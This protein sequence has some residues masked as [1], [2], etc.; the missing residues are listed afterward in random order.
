MPRSRSLGGHQL[1]ALP[2]AEIPHTP[3]RQLLILPQLEPSVLQLTSIWEGQSPC[4]HGDDP[5]HYCT[6]FYLPS[7]LNR[8]VS[9]TSSLLLSCQMQCSWF[10]LHSSLWPCLISVP[11]LS[12][13]GICYFTLSSRSLS[14]Q[15]AAMTKFSLSSKGLQS[16]LS[17]NQALVPFLSLSN[18]F[19]RKNYFK[20]KF[21]FKFY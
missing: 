8:N 4:P 5:S 3:L 15:T 11:F 1:A 2:G 10:C 12:S 14:F 6:L 21:F 17:S 13:M 16:S 19:K 7:L 20:K 9:V 18:S